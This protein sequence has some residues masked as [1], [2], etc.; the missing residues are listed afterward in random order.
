MIIF[1]YL[2]WLPKIPDE[3]LKY[4][5]EKTKEGLISFGSTYTSEHGYS[6]GIRGIIKP[7]TGAQYIRWK[8][9]PE[10]KQWIEENIVDSYDLGAS[11]LQALKPNS[12]PAGH[13]ATHTD[14]RKWVLNY[15]FETGGDDVW[16]SFYTYKSQL[17]QT[18]DTVQPTGL[19]KIYTTKVGTHRWC[20]LNAHVYHD[21][22][23]ITHTRHAISLGLPKGVIDPY[24][25]IHR[26]KDHFSI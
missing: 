12:D 24:T 8:L 10:F 5:A 7:G 23:G 19:T 2:D 26:Y 11:G 21:V 3:F 13:F 16:T 18:P 17:L 25:V 4:P 14:S 1:E 6:R 20:L 22:I 9:R 15:I